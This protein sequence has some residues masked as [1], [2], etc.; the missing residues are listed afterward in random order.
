MADGLDKLTRNIGKSMPRSATRRLVAGRGKYVDDC[1]LKGELQVAFLRS[2]RPHASFRIVD[3]SEAS[4]SNGVVAVL[5]AE[6]IEGLC[7]SW[8]CVLANAPSLF[9]PEQRA[10]AYGRVVFQG[11]PMVMVVALTRAQ[12]EDALE[13]IVVEY[14]DLPAVT[15]LEEAVTDGV[16]AHVGAKSNLAFEHN[17]ST[18]E[19]DRAFEQAAHVVQT[20]LKFNRK[21]GVPLEPRSI[22]AAYDPAAEAILVYASHQMPHQLQ[23]IIADLLDLQLNNVRVICPDVGGGFGIKMHIY[24]EEMA[25]CAA[26]KHLGRPVKYVADR[27]ESMLSDIHAREHIVEAS[28][29]VDDQGGITGLKVDDIQGLGAYS[30]YPRSSTAEGMS[31]LRAMG[32]P[33]KFDQFQARLRSVLQNKVMTGQY[34]S[35]GHPIA[36]AVTE[37]LIEKAAKA[38]GED[39]ITFRK[40]NFV[41]REQMPWVSPV[42]ARMVDLSHHDCID[43]L[44][45]ISGHSDLVDQIAIWRQDGRIVGFGLA[46]FVEFTATG[47]EGYGRGGV[48]VSSQDAVV[49]SIDPFGCV[50]VQSS[51]AEI[52][53]GIAQGLAQIVADAVGVPIKAVRVNLGDTQSAP[54]GGG[55]W[56]SRGAAI[57]GEVAWQAG[58][59]LRTELLNAA[60]AILQTA[61]DK[62]DLIEGTIVEAGRAR[63]TAAELTDLAQFRP[64]ELPQGIQPQLTVA[65]TGGRG[66]DTFLPTNGVQAALVEIDRM[67][68]RIAVLKHWVVEDCGRVINPLLVDEQI[69]GGVVQGIGEALFEHC[70]YTE[71]GQFAIGTLADYLLPMAAD[72]PDVEVAHV[73]TPYSGSLLGA[74]GAGEAG[75]CAAP[76][77][78]LNAVND[79]LSPFGAAVDTLPIQPVAVLRAMGIL[80]GATAV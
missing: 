45:E 25:V 12:A 77:A 53:Q 32:G 16:L 62:L 22:L 7:K 48:R 56:S 11:E 51:A 43:K 64:Y 59:K 8:Q 44:L 75:V 10:L 2:P 24:P 6:D 47:P 80:R 37:S 71:D 66:G 26:T 14:D 31:A 42:G 4:A 28:M 70:R 46:S 78:I 38:I 79:A 21:T 40:R 23:L 50:T 52:G 61:P 39:P 63:M 55:A 74:K 30:I 18:S 72:V 27:I 49:L 19:V 9:S 60:S 67:S 54:H 15:S 33:Y 20:R 29:A 57:T 35:V 58:Q 41:Q 3:T 5:T 76:A 69:R 1:S 36:V 65:H 17:Q 73:V 34:R 68:G 13:L